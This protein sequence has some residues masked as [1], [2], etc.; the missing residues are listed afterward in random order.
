MIYF[1][2]FQLN[3]YWYRYYYNDRFGISKEY[4]RICIIYPKVIEV[5]ENE[6]ELENYEFTNEEIKAIIKLRKLEF[7][8]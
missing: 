5:L 4:N 3:I 7:Q 2:T 8:V 1:S 6:D